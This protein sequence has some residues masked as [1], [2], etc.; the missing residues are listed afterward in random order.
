LKKS[1][2]HRAIGVDT[3]DGR[4]LPAAVNAAAGRG[5]RHSG[6]AAV[7]IQAMQGKVENKVSGLRRGLLVHGSLAHGGKESGIVFIE[8]QPLEH[9]PVR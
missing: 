1:E 2:Y 9:G 6:E 8:F 4:S 5:S 3:P 7:E